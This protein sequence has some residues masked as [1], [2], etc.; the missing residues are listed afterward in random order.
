MPSGPESENFRNSGHRLQTPAAVGINKILPRPVIYCS[1]AAVAA[2]MTL[3]PTAF[4]LFVHQ[5][6]L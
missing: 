4:W 2:V 1:A 5:L 6:L 3:L